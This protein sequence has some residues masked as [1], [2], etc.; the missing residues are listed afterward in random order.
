M[1]K[2]MIALCVVSAVT[3]I[4]GGVWA[5]T[6]AGARAMSVEVTGLSVTKPPK[7]KKNGGMTFSSDVGTRITI[8]V[9]DPNATFLDLM[10][11]ECKVQSFTDDKGT[12]LAN[13][14]PFG[15]FNTSSFNAIGEDGHSLNFTL[16]S[17]DIPAH[18]AK[19]ILVK[20]KAVVLV[21]SDVKEAETK[22]VS[23]AKDTAVKLGTID[24]KISSA[25][26][27]KWGNK[28]GINVTFRASESF[29]SVKSL[30]F[31]GAD[32]KEIESRRTGSSTMGTTHSVTY[33]LKAEVKTATIKVEY[34]SKTE[35]VSV[36]L[37][38]SVGVG[39]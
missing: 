8:Q 4:A 19:E 16:S 30:K 18:G 12:G 28:E 13:F 39:L 38:L 6:P 5:D 9:A 27:P 20:A 14:G 2:T 25:E 33:S 11:K 10:D 17:K 36:P 26:K 35:N 37:D 34:Y 3:V 31:L 24:A 32:G 22:N 15:A 21:G 29:K 7:P 23:L 1:K